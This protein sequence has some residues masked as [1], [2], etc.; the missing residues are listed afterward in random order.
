V[1]AM[2][3]HFQQRLYPAIDAADKESCRHSVQDDDLQQTTADTAVLPFAML[4]VRMTTQDQT[5]SEI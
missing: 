2:S 1:A 3:V 4:D 5:V